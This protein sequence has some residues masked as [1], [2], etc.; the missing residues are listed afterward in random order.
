[1]TESAFDLTTALRRVL[2]RG[3]SDLHL[4]VGNCPLIRVNGVLGD[5]DENAPPLEPRDTELML[6]QMIPSAL[7]SQFESRGEAD[8]SYVAPG[9]ARFRVNAF[10]QRGTISLVL[11]F[12]PSAVPT[13]DEL[14]LPET[15]RTLAEESR[16]IVLVTGSTGAGKST[17]LAAIVDHINRTH[18]RHIVTIEDPIEYVYRDDMSSIEQ[19]EVGIDTTSV[20]AALHHVLRQDPDVI[21]IGEMRDSET[22]R[23]ALSAAETGHL[24][25]S[26]LHTIDASETINRIIELFDL[27]QRQQVRMMLSGTVKGIVSQRLVPTADGNGRTAICEILTTTARV[28]DMI[29]DPDKTGELSDVIAEGDYYGMQSFDQA[30]Y[31]AVTAGLVT[32][33]DAL[34]IASRPHDLQ[35]MIDVGGHTATHVDQLHPV[36]PETF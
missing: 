28:R 9:L 8:F 29:A 1:M 20:G 35:Q 34:Q 31:R 18:R 17:T 13:I 2:E 11:R 26:T 14:G 6:H 23:A 4:K 5:L 3:G 32:P 21:L 30:L 24:V 19:R 10:R 15:I 16:G 7:V 22:A 12:V 25:L 27:S 36:A 33:S